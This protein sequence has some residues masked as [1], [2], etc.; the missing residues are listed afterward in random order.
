MNLQQNMAIA[1][2]AKTQQ[3][4]ASP[5]L[6]NTFSHTTPATNPILFG[7]CSNENAG[8]VTS[9]LW[10]TSETLIEVNAGQGT[11][12]LFVKAAPTASTA[13]NMVFTRVGTA[14]DFHCWALSYTGAKQ[15]AQPDANTTN[16]GTGTSLTGTLT[17]VDDNCWSIMVGR[18]DN[19]NMAPGTNSTERSTPDGY[20]AWAV[21]DTNA[22]KTPAGS[23][24]MT[25]NAGTSSGC[26]LVMSSFSPAAES[27]FTPRI[28]MS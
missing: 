26:T 15:S 25:F 6:T 4:V 23:Q 12:H 10:N 21:F 2:N 27:G 7:A 8:A 18:G 5:N 16:S 22:A 1:F 3:K 13:A 9:C 24:A 14:N 20:D 11:L 17:T 19:A 28:I